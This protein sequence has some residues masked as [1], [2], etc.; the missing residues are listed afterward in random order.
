LAPISSYNYLRR[1]N[2][3]T[4]NPDIQ[5]MYVSKRDYYLSLNER[6]EFCEKN[7]KSDNET[8]NACYNSAIKMG[9]NFIYFSFYHSIINKTLL[10]KVIKNLNNYP[11]NTNNSLPTNSKILYNLLRINEFLFFSFLKY[12]FQLMNQIARLKHRYLMYPIP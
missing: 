2:S 6:V 10:L 3:I 12:Y 1:N 9:F 4:N 8:L 11:A 5:H 7:L